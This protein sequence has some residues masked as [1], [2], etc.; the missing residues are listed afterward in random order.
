MVI[1]V[2][3]VCQGR[4][5]GIGDIAFELPVPLLACG[6]HL[7]NTFCLGKGKHVFLSHHIGDLENVARSLRSWTIRILLPKSMSPA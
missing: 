7:K 2:M 1:T 3:S 4:V 6:G 5:Y